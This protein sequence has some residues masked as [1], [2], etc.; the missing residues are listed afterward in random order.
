MA[1]DKE[2]QS[3]GSGKD[4]VTGN[5][6]QEVNPQKGNTNPQH[7]DFYA[8]R[9]ENEE[10]GP[11]QGGKVSPEQ[12]KDQVPGRENWAKLLARPR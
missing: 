10:N 6:S 2:P 5:T 12:K 9:R 4:W 8:P 1:N 11:E 3:Y 7:S